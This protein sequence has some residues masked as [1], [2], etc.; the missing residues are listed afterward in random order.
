MS[1]SN[2][3]TIKG[4]SHRLPLM[5]ALAV[6]V[7]ALVVTLG[8]QFTGEGKVTRT[9]G[10]VDRERLLQFRDG[11]AGTVIVSDANTRKIIVRFGR[12]EGA[13]VR[14]SMRALSHNR[15]QMGV[16]KGQPYR[17]VE[18]AKGKLSIVDPVTGKFIKLNA[19][20]RVAMEGFSHLLKTD[21]ADRSAD[22]ASTLEKG[23]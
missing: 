17:L 16:E 9:I 5:A 2:E 7:L 13:F 1:A 15:A 21:D 8:T 22:A 10:E 6:V 14:Q 18:T 19:F 11:E 23:A 4:P 3:T 20:G 12:G